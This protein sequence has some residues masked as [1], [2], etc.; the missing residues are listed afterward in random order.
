MCEPY[1]QDISRAILEYF[2][3]GNKRLELGRKAKQILEEQLYWEKIIPN[4]IENYKR[5]INNN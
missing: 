5:I 3:L 2:K 4:M 1:A